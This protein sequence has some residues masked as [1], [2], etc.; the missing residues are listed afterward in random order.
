MTDIFILNFR[1]NL[2]KKTRLLDEKWKEF[3]SVT[4]SNDF[5]LSE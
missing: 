1:C 4:K 5:I 2:V 3:L